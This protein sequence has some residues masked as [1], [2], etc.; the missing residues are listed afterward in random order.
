MYAG[1][2]SPDLSPPA[3]EKRLLERTPTGPPLAVACAPTNPRG[4]SVP[5]EVVVSL[6]RFHFMALGGWFMAVVV[7]LG[8]RAALGVPPSLLEALGGLAIAL[9]PALMVLTVFRGAPPQTIAE[10]LYDAE[11]ARNFAREQ[12]VAKT[13][14]PK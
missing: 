13:T 5:R 2:V 11:H 3:F 7:A 14:D 6:T 8:V 4:A 1:T 12:L 10:V 9:A